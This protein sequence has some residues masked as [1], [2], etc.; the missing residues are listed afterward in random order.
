MSTV[1]VSVTVSSPL[2]ALGN[3]LTPSSESGF[4]DVL[5]A[6]IQLDR[7]IDSS[8]GETEPELPAEFADTDISSS[9]QAETAAD[10]LM[11]L[12]ASRQMDTSLK[13]N[14]PA[15]PAIQSEETT[16]NNTALPADVVVLENP[17]PES[18]PVVSAD[19]VLPADT[20]V[21]ANP[22]PEIKP[23]VNDNPEVKPVH[24]SAGD[25]IPVDTEIKE[26]TAKFESRKVQSNEPVELAPEATTTSGSPPQLNQIQ[27]PNP[28]K[29]TNKKPVNTEMMENTTITDE[30]IDSSVKPAVSADT[31]SPQDDKIKNT[32]TDNKTGI[33]DNS[34]PAPDISALLVSMS[35][36]IKEQIDPAAVVSEPDVS[37]TEVTTDANIS[38]DNNNAGLAAKQASS[39]NMLQGDVATLKNDGDTASS[40]DAVSAAIFPDEKTTGTTDEKPS[41]S[42][43]AT[44]EYVITGSANNESDNQASVDMGT[45]K[46]TATVNSAQ[47]ENHAAGFTGKNELSS[48]NALS[49]PAQGLRSPAQGINEQLPSLYMKDGQIEEHELAARVVLMVGEKWQEAELQL[50]P[51]GMGKIRVQLSVDQEQQTHVQ[52]MVQHSQAKD[53]LDQSLPR[54]RELLTQHGLQ[55]GQTQV[56]QQTQDN[57][58]QS[59]NQQMAN[60]S[61]AEQQARRESSSS[62]RAFSGSNDDEFVQTVAVSASQAT[63]IDFYA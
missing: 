48:T 34:I 63:G 27:D 13:I 37:L 29:A 25:P 20:V 19:T 14:N 55:P 9:L 7:P 60:N 5:G 11:T 52:F 59:W 50:E 40:P 12:Q 22:G 35:P 36:V 32:A 43:P 28:V 49:E 57:S 17:A 45:E 42:N 30:A 8:A 6:S 58:G 39:G 23:V 2:T 31:E 46:N 44:T 53:A 33:S 62:D 41:T 56:Q 24:S 26:V 18:K 38:S 21:P 54:L 47:Y 61:A 15:V 4:S 16:F 3:S 10:M 51:Q 1:S